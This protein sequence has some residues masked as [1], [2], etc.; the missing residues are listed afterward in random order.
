MT[1]TNDIFLRDAGTYKRDINPVDNYKVQM[2]RATMLRYNVDEDK[3]TELV[4]RVLSNEKYIKDPI[5]SFYHRDRDTLD[6]ELVKAPLSQYLADV[7][8]SN[9]IMVPSGTTYVGP[10]VRPSLIAESISEDSILRG[11]TKKLAAK[12]KAEKDMDK[13]QR[14]DDDQTN[15]KLDSNVYSGLFNANGNILYNPSAHSS[16][17]STTRIITSIGNANNERM[18]SGNRHYHNYRTTIN[19]LVYTVSSLDKLYDGVPLYQLIGN[20]VSTYGLVYPTVEQTIDCVLRSTWLYW[21]HKKSEDKLRTFIGT[22]DKAQRAAIVYIGDMFHLRHCNDSVI[23]GMYEEL[24][25]KAYAPCTAEMAAELY[26]FDEEIMNLVHKFF[27]DEMRGKGKDYSKLFATIPNTVGALYAT[28]KHI[29]SVLRKYEGL[30]R[31]FFGTD[32]I[33]PTVASMPTMMRR[34]G[35]MGDTDSTCTS[36]DKWGF[37]FTGEKV[38]N[39]PCRDA[40]NAALF[41]SSQSMRHYLAVCSGHMGLR[42]HLIFKL[43]MKPE[44]YWDTFACTDVSKTYYAQTDVK[45]GSVYEKPDIEIKGVNLMNSNTPM[46]VRKMAKDM[47]TRF[48]AAPGQGKRLNMG[49]ELRNVAN[50]ERLIRSSLADGEMEFYRTISINGEHGYKQGPEQSNHRWYTFWKEIYGAKYKVI[51][52]PPYKTFKVKTTLT[53]KTELANWIDSI[54]DKEIAGRLQKWI[55]R[56]NRTSLPTIYVPIDHVGLYGMPPEIVSV[57]NYTDITMDLVNMCYIVLSSL[58]YIVKPKMTL[59]DMGY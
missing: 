16:L 8:S 57:I 27:M 17:T 52:E 36:A 55:V 34:S 48:L 21:E 15:I 6:K 19:N 42:K 23:H 10:E 4:Q 22:L 26:G 14:A 18:I 7:V 46:R 45:E 54:E 56:T 39:Q 12:Y 3:A 40:A 58:N 47:M 33:P 35:V 37:W 2:V 5:V 44:Y 13:F 24:T 20:A 38:L 43:S 49:A 32:N 29:L 11:K 28:Y 53:N 9:E 50:L 30:I 51:A 59:V 31:A 1:T 41:M 25:A